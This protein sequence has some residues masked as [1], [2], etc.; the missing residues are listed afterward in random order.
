M[1]GPKL[2]L[3]IDKIGSGGAQTQM[4]LLARG[5]Q[6]AGANVTLLTYHPSEYLRHLDSLRG[7]RLVELRKLSP[8]GLNLPFA[9]AAELRRE[10]Y[11][12]AL[13]FLPGPSAYLQIAA[14][15]ASFQRPVVTGERNVF[16]RGRPSRRDRVMRLFQNRA[17]WIVTNSEEQSEALCRHFPNVSRKVRVIRNAVDLELFRPV[18]ELPPTPTVLG[19]GRVVPEKNILGLIDAFG[20]LRRRG[21]PGLKFHWVGRVH[22]KDYFRECS[23]RLNVLELSDSWSWW[24]EQTDLRPFYGLATVLALPSFIEGMPNVAAEAL[25]SGVP[26]VVS[27]AGE[28]EWLTDKGN[29]GVTCDPAQSRSIA[30]GI[31]FLL[32][33]SASAASDRRARCRVFAESALSEEVMVESY[34]RLFW[35][36]GGAD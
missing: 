19:I 1:S 3:I 7:I 36:P 25:A 30:D 26:I 6:K 10:G 23:H 34:L 5:L 8:Q 15:L 2:L 18:G 35:P 13:A 24:P 32:N 31:E 28:G 20:Q 22:D 16:P 27:R 29:T 12:G 11:D 4:V 21:A 14:T 17:N 33:E 9:V